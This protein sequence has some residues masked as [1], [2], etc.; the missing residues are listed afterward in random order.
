MEFLFKEWKRSKVVVTVAQLCEYTQEQ[1]IVTQPGRDGESQEEKGRIGSQIPAREKLDQI[2][3]ENIIVQ[4]KTARAEI[5]QEQ[6]VFKDKSTCTNTL[7]SSC[8]PCIFLLCFS[9]VQNS[10]TNLITLGW[11]RDS[12]TF[13]TWYL[14]K[15]Q[16]PEPLPDLRFRMCVASGIQF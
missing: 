14:L 4:I 6:Y 7:S 9:S 11:A 8:L 10:L 3:W 5:K 13:T 16:V 15:A 2:N 12:Q 1:W